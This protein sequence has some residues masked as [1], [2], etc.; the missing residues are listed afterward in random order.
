[1][2]N[3]LLMIFQVFTGLFLSLL[4][5]LQGRGTGLS[6]AF[7]GAGETF[8]TRRGFEKGLFY[9]TIVVSILFVLALLAVLL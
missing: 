1:M 4:I 3:D 2:M 5:L 6:S 7:G 9:L 8:R